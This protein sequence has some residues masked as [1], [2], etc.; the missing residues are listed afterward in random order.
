[1]GITGG[2][3][4]R[5]ALLSGITNTWVDVP[6]HDP[7]L[8]EAASILALSTLSKCKRKHLLPDLGIWLL[9]SKRKTY[10]LKKNKR[11]CKKMKSL[12]K[13][14]NKKSQVCSKPL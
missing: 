2:K 9:R 13:K 11:C 3:G 10:Y 5:N 7:E 14:Q 12:G 6:A 1:M 8:G 4:K